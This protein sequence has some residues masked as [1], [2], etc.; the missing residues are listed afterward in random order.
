MKR[1]LPVFISLLLTGSLALFV[2]HAKQNKAAETSAL[3]TYDIGTFSPR[4]TCARSPK[5]LQKIGIAQPVMIDLSQ[6]Q[7]TGM[8][9]RYGKHFRHVLHPKQWEQYEHF[10]TYALDNV[11][12]VYLIPTPFISIRPTTFNLQ[13]KL[14][15]L[16]SKS[17]KIGIFMNFDDVRP[18]ANNPYGLNAIV[19]DCDD[20]TLWVAAIDESDYRQQRGVIYHIDPQTHRI[21]QQVNGFDALTLAIVHTSRGKYLL[22]GSARDSALYAF[23]MNKNSGMAQT[24]IRLFALPDPNEH[25]RKIKIDAQNK[26]ALQSIPFSY[27][28]I[29]RASKR[30][31]T[32][33]EA[34][35]LEDQQRWNVKK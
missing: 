13:K 24:P 32:H 26:I 19:Y 20:H 14:Y 33:F 34:E 10:S 2:I 11:G 25:I 16:D 8:A 35:W 12:N 21:M 9:L 29:A 4:R 15:R 31:R 30:D 5:F 28:L 27:S 18:S 22:A 6:K 23:S 3:K 7:Y 1:T 17:G